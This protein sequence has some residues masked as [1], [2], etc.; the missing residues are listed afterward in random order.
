MVDGSATRREGS[1]TEA[2]LR[3]SWGP[4]PPGRTS[5]YDRYGTCNMASGVRSLNC[6][7]PGLSLIH[8]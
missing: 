2:L 1:S 3:G 5:E 6:A 8:I 4:E 7:A